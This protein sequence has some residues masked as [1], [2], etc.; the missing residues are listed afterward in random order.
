MAKSFTWGAAAASFQIEG[1]LNGRGRGPCV[2]DMFC[3]Q[4]GKVRFQHHGN[5]A[6]NHIDYMEQ[7]VATMAAIGLQAYRFSVSWPRVIPNGTGEINPDGLAFYDRLVDTLLAN[8][9]TPW[10]TLFHW[11]YPYQLFLQ[12]GW[13]NPDSAD[14]FADYTRIIV[15]K[16]SDRVSHWMTLN[17]PQCFIHFGHHTGYHAPGLK[18]GFKEV[19]TAAHN[20]LLAHGKAVQT[21]RSYSKTDAIVG[22]APV[23]Y[24]YVPEQDS[25]QCVN[26]AKQATFAITQQDCWNNSWFADPMFLGHYPE[27][28]LALHQPYLPAF[29][30]HDMKT[31]CQPLDFYGANIYTAE[32]ITTNDAGQVNPVPPLEGDRFTSMDWHVVPESLYWAS[33]F[34]YERYNVPVIITENGMANHDWVD[35]AGR[36]QDPQRII[37]LKQY[38]DALLRARAEGVP[39]DGY[40]AWSIMDNFEWALGYDRRFGLVHVDYQTMKR[41]IKESGYW[42]KA[43]INKP[44]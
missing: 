44:L 3:Q 17:E 18:L 9:I 36:V 23:G 21:I 25:D 39:I 29:G 38:T 24:V 40:F 43:R 28:G 32:T 2:W 34:F 31:I 41:T 42:Y 37:L 7:D 22:A 27:D 16:L 35:E 13:L 5:N 19:L 20:A 10:I 6:C 8:N 26:A 4:P 14:W 11:D 12:G 30:Q 15:D 1:S 33:K